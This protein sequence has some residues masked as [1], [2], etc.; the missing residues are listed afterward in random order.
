MQVEYVH[1]SPAAENL[2]VEMAR[3]S[4]PKNAKNYETGPKLIQYLL[5]CGHWSPLEMVSLCVRIH[6]T[7]DISSQII[8]HRSF[9]YQEFSTRYA[10]TKKPQV[11]HFRLQD[12]KNRQN[13]YDTIPAELQADY[14]NQASRLIE[15][16]WSLYERLLQD[17]VARETA[18]RILP[19]CTPTTVLMHGTLRSWVHYLAVRCDPSTQ[20]E[21]REVALNVAS[22]FREK[23]PVV[24]E[25]AFEM[26]GAPFPDTLPAR[27]SLNPSA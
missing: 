11:P 17:G 27:G 1:S 23:F 22:I 4:N 21:H 10:V 12:K 6:T 25:A 20:L 7:R 3:V 16:S 14:Q 19:L 2:I 8:R 15:E 9:S 18:R 24:A 13:S 5:R 26:D